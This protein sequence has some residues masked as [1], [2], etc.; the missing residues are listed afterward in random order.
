VDNK[1]RR[2][3]V[4]AVLTIVETGLGH[5]YAGCLKR[6]IV[7]FAVGEALLLF[8]ALSLTLVVPGRIFML[9][10]IG[11]GLAYWLFCIADAAIIAK[12]NRTN[13][14]P[15]KYNK[16]YAYIGYVVAAQI[17][18]GILLSAVVIP[19]FVQAFRM[20]TG[21]MEPTLLIGDRVLVSKCIYFFSEPER[22]DLVVFKYPRDPKS[23]Y[24]KRLIGMPGEKIEVKE[25][26]V[27]INDQPLDE[28]YTQ[29]I[30]ESSQFT[31]YGPAYIP[32]KGD[33]IEILNS[34]KKVNDA[35]MGNE[36]VE[37]Y[38]DREKY[39][40]GSYTVSQNQYFVL[41]DNRDNSMDSRV[42]GS[43]PRDYFLGK[44]LNVYWSF[45]T[46]RDE[47]LRNSDLDL[48]KQSPYGLLNF[49][50]KTRWERI[51]L[52]VR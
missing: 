32:K 35:A 52:P 17:W 11:I 6:G 5:M 14:T 13:Y 10:I 7:L 18:G 36:I 51:F 49:F 1:P 20:P 21:S 46:P 26:T 9:S 25:R 19:F 31:H 23:P 47:Y 42:F 38:P 24:I 45:E 34:V 3:W 43:V 15:V 22:G 41:G 28:K 39:S 29:H 4:A 44:V 33:K 40:E 27:Y 50:R 16:W 30:W 48:V 8:M 12:A 37:S 2:P